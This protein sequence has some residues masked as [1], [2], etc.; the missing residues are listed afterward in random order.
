MWSICGQIVWWLF[1]PELKFGYWGW[2]KHDVTLLRDRSS[3]WLDLHTDLVRVEVDLRSIILTKD[4]EKCSDDIDVAGFIVV[5]TWDLFADKY[6][7]SI[8][9]IMLMLSIRSRHF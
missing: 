3:W 8:D 5:S 2:I 1:W 9:D 7:S 4:H 6:H